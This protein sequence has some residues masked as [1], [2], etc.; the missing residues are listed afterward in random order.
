MRLQRTA[1]SFGL[2]IHCAGTCSNHC[3][4]TCSNH[5]AGTCSN[6]RAG[7]ARNLHAGRV[8]NGEREQR[9]THST[10]LLQ[11]ALDRRRDR[12]RR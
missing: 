1:Q 11:P 2:C 3:A 4:G 6:H 5:C 9:L 12:S 8:L 7:T 10:V